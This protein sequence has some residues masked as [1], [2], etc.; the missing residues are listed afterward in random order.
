MMRPSSHSIQSTAVLAAAGC[1]LLGLLIHDYFLLTAAVLAGTGIA[2]RGI[3]SLRWGHLGIELLVTVAAV[4][5]IMLGEYFEAA[6]VT[7]LF[8]LGGWLETL[9][10]RKTRN[11]LQ[12]LLDS[13]P[14]TASVIRDGKESIVAIRELSPGDT[15]LVRPGERIPVDGTVLSGTS[16]VNESTI[17]GESMPSDK[18]EGSSVYSATMNQHGALHI[19]TEKIGSDTVV[20]AVIAR[21]EEAQDSQPRGQR[22]VDRFARVYTPAVLVGSLL[23]YLV[24][25]NLHTAL[26]LLVVSCPGAMVLAAPTAVVTAIGRAARQGV[27]IRGGAELELLARIDALATDKTGT[28]T[29]GNIQVTDIVPRATYRD[30]LYWA[31]IAESSSEHPLGR[32]IRRHAKSQLADLPSAESFTA[33]IGVGITALYQQNTIAITKPD[34]DT[35]PADLPAGATVVAVHLNKQLL[36]FIILSDTIRS[37]ARQAM[38]QLKDL[39]IRHIVLLT[40]DN[41]GA[42]QTA[43]GQT[44]ISEVH[45]GL[46]PEHKLQ[47]VRTMMQRGFTTAVLGDGINDAPALTAADIGISM[48]VNATDLANDAADVALMSEKLTLIPVA[49]RIARH[50]VRT[51]QINIGIAVVTVGLLILGVLLGY[52]HMA[53]GMLIHQGSILLVILNGIRPYTGR[54]AAADH[55]PS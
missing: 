49:V 12:Q 6:A 9:A 42:A 29:S 54:T 14:D 13:I 3:A 35:L 28:L 16:S 8:A 5:G 55:G 40:G 7:T 23:Y 41:E 21:V 53:A 43:A 38:L 30:L 22:M 51:M 37:D 36:G 27:L 46:L 17:T 50:A 48:G 45:A 39:G 25:G 32:A 20:A 15:V 19:R 44:G 24:T 1:I 34:A 11:A 31:G 10:M 52:I 2:R 26:T 4:G 33:Q 47:H 18:H